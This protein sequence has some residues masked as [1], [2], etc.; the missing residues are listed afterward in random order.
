MSE[1]T[2]PTRTDATSTATAGK[3]YLIYLNTGTTE[4]APTWTLLGGQRSGDLNREADEIDASHKTS[5]GWK[6]TLP[7]L[8]SWSI[9]LETVYL[10]GD[11]GAKFL[12]AAF[13]AG[14]QVHV[15]FE[16]PDKSFVTGWGSITECSL[17]TPHDDVAT[18]KGT[19]SGDGPLSEQSKG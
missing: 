16:Y 12:E 6:S 9:D 17:S 18:L 10:A 2:F 19:I 11:T 14:K 4:A 7:G 8:R 13:L 5:G 1:Y 3:D 15:K